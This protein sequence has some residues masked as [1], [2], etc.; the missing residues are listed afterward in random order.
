MPDACRRAA[1]DAVERLH[2]TFGVDERASRFRER[3]D[4][5]QDVSVFS[6]G[7]ERRH[8]D[9]HF[10]LL[11]R[12][13]SL[14]RIGRVE[15][16][17][18]VQQHITLARLLEHFASVQTTLA[19][20]CV[21]EMRADRV[22]GFREETQRCAGRVCDPLRRGVNRGEVRMADR[23]VAEQHQAAVRR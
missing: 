13:Q 2:G 21:H 16:R 22:G 19:R 11:Q 23:A 7:L 5:Q 1:H 18:D 17:F 15:F 3:C 14:R 8:H 12:G 20:Q 6:A 9:H 4:R 10:S